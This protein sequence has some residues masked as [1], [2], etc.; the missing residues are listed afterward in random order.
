MRTAP[1]GRQP[2][3]PGAPVLTFLSPTLRR[4]PA[5]GPQ[6]FPSRARWAERA[7]TEAQGVRARALLAAHP[8]GVGPAP[9]RAVTAAY[10]GARAAARAGAGHG[11]APRG[12]AGRAGRAGRA[13]AAAASQGPGPPPPP[14]SR[15][16]GHRSVG[17][18]IN[19]AALADQSLPRRASPKS[20]LMRVRK[21]AWY[22]QFQESDGT[23]Y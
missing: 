9:G 10:F 17:L 22:S 16:R 21:Q 19:L 1:G 3:H 8:A 15:R 6:K 12:A 23:D 14:G 13:V 18:L 7:G 5:L 11:R 20:T 2:R 4:A